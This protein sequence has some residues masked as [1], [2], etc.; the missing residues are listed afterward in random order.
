MRKLV[1]R[2]G[3]FLDRLIKVF[4][5]LIPAIIIIF[6]LIQVVSFLA[7][8]YFPEMRVAEWG[9]IEHGM[10]VHTLLLRDETVLY[11]P[12]K[13]EV[14]IL[15]TDGSTLRAGDV[16]AEVVS[17]AFARRFSGDWRKVLRAVAGRL[18]KIEEELAEIEKDISVTSRSLSRLRSGKN[19]EGTEKTLQELR[20]DQRRLQAFK[21]EVLREGEVR[22][23]SGWQEQ[24]RIIRAE[25]PGTF[26]LRLDGKEGVGL[27]VLQSEEDPFAGHNITRRSQNPAKPVGKLITGT[28]QIIVCQVPK[29]TELQTPDEGEGCR[30]R[31]GNRE[32]SLTFIGVS[33]NEAD[34]FWIFEEAT[35]D[36]ELLDKRAFKA[37][38][39]FK[40]SSGIRIPRSAVHD[41]KEGGGKV[42]T[43]SRGAK[44]E[45]EVEILDIS[46][47][48][49]IVRGISLGT[50]VYC[51]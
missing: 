8:S 10:W 4:P 13:G 1:V 49:A 48:W 51:R 26:R 29:G 37:Y 15:A 17:P 44:K 3:S 33:F 25:T 32:F 20:T 47:E 2:P 36:P 14:K 28:K 38:L 11:P 16:V 18:Y 42:Y 7:R 9:T 43:V 35:L 12:I 27:E 34:L 41:R 30:L 50:P 23:G 31:V 46:E 19:R 22:F 6:L 40:T 5:R 21:N 24:Y 39:V 45:I